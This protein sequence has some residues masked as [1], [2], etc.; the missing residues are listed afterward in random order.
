MKDKIQKWIA[1]KLPKGIAK[2]ATIR[3]AVS[4]T[5]GSYSNVIVP[6]L[7]VIDCLKRWEKNDSTTKNS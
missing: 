6:E 2:W 1:W 4:A 7:T 5:N 3:V